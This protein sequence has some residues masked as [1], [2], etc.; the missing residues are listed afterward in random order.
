MIL[1]SVSSL[2]QKELDLVLIGVASFKSFYKILFG[3]FLHSA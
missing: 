3:T 2:T 1:L